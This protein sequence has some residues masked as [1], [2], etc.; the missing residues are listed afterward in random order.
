MGS[1]S[2]LAGLRKPRLSPKT[3][4]EDD[5]DAIHETRYEVDADDAALV[6]GDAR[7]RADRNDVVD[8]DHVARRAADV[9]QGENDDRRE[10]DE[11]R[12]AFIMDSLKGRQIIVT[13]CEPSVVPGAGAGDISYF[14][15]SEGRVEA[16]KDG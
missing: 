3:E 13:S 7:G 10:L 9:L 2:Y 1:I 5:N 16:R 8:A 11:R 14:R 12:R 6:A 4:D 15:V